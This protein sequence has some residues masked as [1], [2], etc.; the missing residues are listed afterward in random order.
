MRF[1]P[2]LV[3][4]LVALAGC[5]GAET[6]VESQEANT[7]TSST[8]T[9]TTGASTGSSSSSTTTT[10]SSG[11]HTTAGTRTSSSSAAS[12]VHT[13]G[14]DVTVRARDGQLEVV[15]V[16]AAPGWRGDQRLEQPTRLI[17]S[18]ER[19]GHRV[20]VTVELTPTGIVTNTRSVATG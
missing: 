11:S 16:A 13:D 8:H 20:D 1:V 15:D 14:G 19:E 9:S 18:F 4:G 2:A 3:L 12:T 5:T 17:V 10:T 6:D 7:N